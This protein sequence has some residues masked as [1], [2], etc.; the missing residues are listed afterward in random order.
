VGFNIEEVEGRHR[1][2]SLQYEGVD[3]E[4][5][6]FFRDM[7]ALVEMHPGQ[8]NVREFAATLGMIADRRAAAYGNPQTDPLRYVT[9]GVDGELSTF[10]PELLGY[11]SDSH[12]TFV[13]GN[14]HTDGFA[15]ITTDPNFIG[16]EMAIRRG[17]EKCRHTCGYFDLCLGGAPANKLFENGSFDSTDTLYC[18]LS[19]KALID[20]V[21]Q[22][23]VYAVPE[24]I[25]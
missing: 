3:K 7:L 21:L 5:A 19:K 13:F 22:H 8:L 16:T 10:S 11:R 9:V 23:A 18:R 15:G 12:R 4:M 20:V 1:Q 14:V 6:A 25:A 17:V 2:S 24:T